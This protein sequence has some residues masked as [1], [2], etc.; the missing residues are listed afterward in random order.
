M[1]GNIYIYIRIWIGQTQHRPCLVWAE[2]I[3][4]HFHINWKLRQMTVSHCIKKELC[5]SDAPIFVVF[6]L[7]THSSL[8]SHIHFRVLLHNIFWFTI[9]WIIVQRQYISII[10]SLIL[11]KS[12]DVSEFVTFILYHALNHYSR[13]NNHCC[14]PSIS[15]AT[16]ILPV[17]IIILTTHTVHANWC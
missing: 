17:R 9:E 4:L 7:M 16:S 5:D 10:S 11:V 3:R 2:T 1:A 14:I 6:F 13:W 12:F 8:E 15:F